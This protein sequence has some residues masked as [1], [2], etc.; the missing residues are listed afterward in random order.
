MELINREGIALVVDLVVGGETNQYLYLL[1]YFQGVVRFEWKS[2]K[3]EADPLKIQ[4]L[5]GMA[6]TLHNDTLVVAN[7]MGETYA[8]RTFQIVNGT[9][10]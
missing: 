8:A 2:G 9:V 10:N 1:D 7:R 3:L 4:L 6:L 5:N